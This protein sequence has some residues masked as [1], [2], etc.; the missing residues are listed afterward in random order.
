MWN[1]VDFYDTRL[2]MGLRL[3]VSDASAVE[4]SQ[5][6]SHG[7]EAGGCCKVVRVF[8]LNVIHFSHKQKKGN[9]LRLVYNAEDDTI[10]QWF[11]NFS[12]LRTPFTAPKSAAEPFFF[13]KFF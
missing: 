7:R 6:L 2:T 13:S 9:S 4:S 10:E 1:F 11:S 8:S 12:L 5:K 3:R